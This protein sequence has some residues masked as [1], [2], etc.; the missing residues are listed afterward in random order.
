MLTTLKVS[1][2]FTQ[3]YITCSSCRFSMLKKKSLFTIKT[4]IELSDIKPVQIKLWLLRYQRNHLSSHD[5]SFLVWLVSCLTHTYLGPCLMFF[6]FG[7]CGTGIQAPLN[8]A[9]L[10]VSTVYDPG[11]PEKQCLQGMHVFHIYSAKHL[12]QAHIHLHFYCPY[13]LN[14][15]SPLT[16]CTSL[17]P[18]LISLCLGHVPYLM[19]T[20][21]YILPEPLPSPHSLSSGQ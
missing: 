18:S 11:Q 2:E 6:L 20:D 9:Y 5:P 19:P 1:V 15:L 7:T 16:I 8:T 4:L 13:C 14:L 21:S 10:G 3:N 12:T 17:T